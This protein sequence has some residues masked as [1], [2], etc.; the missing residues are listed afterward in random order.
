MIEAEQ[1]GKTLIKALVN[2]IAKVSGKGDRLILFN[3]ML[4]IGQ[5]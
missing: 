2:A 3:I 4:I 5:K 1:H